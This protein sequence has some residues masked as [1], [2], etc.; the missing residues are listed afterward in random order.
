MTPRTFF[1]IFIK[2]IGLYLI[3]GLATLVFQFL[4]TLFWLLGMGT[5][6]IIGTV[7]F[8]LL[9]PLGIYVFIIRLC[10]FKT[11]YIIDKLALDKHFTEEK[12][13]INIHRSTVLSIAAIVIGGLIFIEALPSL[14]SQIYDYFKQDKTSEDTNVSWMIFDFVKVFI[15]Y[16]L[17]SSN[18]FIVNFI[19]RKRIRQ[20]SSDKLEDSNSQNVETQ[21]KS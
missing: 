14:C 12:F 6:N 17:I 10:L 2:I 11:N 8:G 19:E 21:E 9:L 20:Y 1:T 7:I 15:G 5:E 4:S 3:I 18:R 16:F 13:E